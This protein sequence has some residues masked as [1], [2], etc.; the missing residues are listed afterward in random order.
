MMGLSSKS[1]VPSSGRNLFGVL[2]VALV[3][4]GGIVEEREEGTG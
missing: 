3:F 2:A 1:L 4:G